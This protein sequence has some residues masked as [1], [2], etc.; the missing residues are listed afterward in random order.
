MDKKLIKRI[1]EVAK[2]QKY[3]EELVLTLLEIS[4]VSRLLA[5]RMLL[6]KHKNETVK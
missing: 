5:E 6:M 1:N 3:D 2:T 4:N